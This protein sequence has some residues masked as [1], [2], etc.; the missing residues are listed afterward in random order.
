MDNTALRIETKHMEMMKY[1]RGRIDNMPKKERVLTDMMR[2][3]M[4][5]AWDLIGFQRYSKNRLPLLRELDAQ[6]N[7]LLRLVR[8]ANDLGYFKGEPDEQG[9]TKAYRIWSEMLV[10]EGKD[11][12]KMIQ[13]YLTKGH[14]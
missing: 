2:D 6:I 7:S 10:N 14:N 13:P 8:L 12:G 11:V 9:D 3:K 4:Y 1:A 5:R